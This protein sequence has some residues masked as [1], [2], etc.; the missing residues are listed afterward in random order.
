LALD[1]AQLTREAADAAQKRMRAMARQSNVRYS[2]VVVRGSPANEICHAANEDVDLIVISTHGRTGF[3]HVLIG[4]VA[5]HVVRQAHCPVL[6]IP[7][8]RKSRKK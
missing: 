1:A 3:E 6:V 7:A 4:S 5:Q 8:R 2:T